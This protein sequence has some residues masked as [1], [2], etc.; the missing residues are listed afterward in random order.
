MFYVQV[1]SPDG[2][3]QITVNPPNH[4]ISLTNWELMTTMLR[5]VGPQQQ[6]SLVS[7][8]SQLT[9][10][11]HPITAP[12]SSPAEPF[13]FVHAHFHL[14]LVLK[15]LHFNSFLHMESKMSPS[16]NKNSFYYGIALRLSISLEP[17]GCAG[18]ASTI[19]ICIFWHTP[20][21]SCPRCHLKTVGGLGFAAG[22]PQ[23]C[24]CWGNWIGLYLTM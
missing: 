10:E 15:R 14:D 7:Y 4:V 1:Y 12:V 11:G 5:R 19:C 6:Q 23:M 3:S 24:S 17:L 16:N 21:C 18:R 13:P 20:S 8:Y 2:L 22:K 9:Y